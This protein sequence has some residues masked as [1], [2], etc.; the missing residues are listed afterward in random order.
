M[1]GPIDLT[2]MLIPIFMFP[3]TAGCSPQNGF[4][5][6]VPRDAD[7]RTDSEPGP[8]AD[9]DAERG[10]LAVRPRAIQTPS[11]AVWP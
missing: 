6:V 5:E 7:P 9:S 10:P 2:E 3:S 11:Q 4:W 1:L 8:P